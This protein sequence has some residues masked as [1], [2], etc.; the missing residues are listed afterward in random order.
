MKPVIKYL[1]S[2]DRLPWK[3]DNEKGISTDDALPIRKSGVWI[4]QK[5]RPLVYYS[6]IFNQAMKD[7]PSWHERVYFELFAGPGRCLVRE[8]NKEEPGSPLKVLETNYTRFIF[9]EMSE[10]AALALA[11]RIEGHPNASKVEIWCGDCADA[12]EKVQIAQKSLVFTFIDPT[13]IGHAPF[14]LISTLAAKARSDIML[15]IPIGTDIKRNLHNYLEQT[16]EDAPLTRYLGSE[17]W[18]DLPKNT[19]ANF[20][21]GFLELYEQQLRGIGYN[22]VGKTKEVRTPGNVP[23]YYL[24]FASRHQLGE[25]FW[26]DTLKRV[27]APEFN[28]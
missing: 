6:Q 17:Q 7:N 13:R 10:P 23:L 14:K 21:R 12:V 2:A 20:C 11:A 1:P 18:V 5:H 15:N 28:F 22:F 27:N 24:F 3:E 25:K 19:V 8:T 4:E 16:G 26:N 9:V